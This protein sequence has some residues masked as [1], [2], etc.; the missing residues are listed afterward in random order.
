MKI[1]PHGTPLIYV[2]RSEVE[3]SDGSM[4]IDSWHVAAFTPEEAT[5]LVREEISKIS[6]ARIKSISVNAT[7]ETVRR[8][9]R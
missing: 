4:E 1:I 8:L 6:T 3:R 9:P 7:T 5:R 2:V